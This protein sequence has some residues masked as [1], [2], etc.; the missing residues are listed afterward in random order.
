MNLRLTFNRGDD[1]FV[2]VRCR[3]LAGSQIT[4]SPEYNIKINT[5]PFIDIT[6]P[7]G[8]EI[9]YEYIPIT[10]D[11][12]DSFDYDGDS[13]SFKWYRSGPTG[14]EQFGITALMSASFA[15]GEH[16][17][18][19]VVTDSVEN[20]ASFT[21]VILVEGEDD[22]PEKYTRDTDGDTIP[23][24]WE[25]QYH[26]DYL[27][28]DSDKDPD[29]DGFTNL[30]EYENSTSPIHQDSSPNYDFDQDGINDIW[31]R[32]NGLNHQDPSD[33]EEDPDHDG[34]TN[35]E[36]YKGDTD[37]NDFLSAPGSV[38]PLRTIWYGSGAYEHGLFLLSLIFFI[39]AIFIMGYVYWMI[40]DMKRRG[41]DGVRSY[42]LSLIFFGIIV[43]IMYRFKRRKGN[44][45]NCV[46]CGN[47]R[48]EE[49]KTCPH[50]NCLV[51]IKKVKKPMLRLKV[52]KRK[53][54]IIYI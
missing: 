18:K 46:V 51:K 27:K 34:Y 29:D 3:N 11:A 54:K 32:V 45:I 43:L 41:M 5:F 14:M 38:N 16:T 22:D 21:F 23:D 36:E 53:K 52:L 37:P 8:G 26:L 25:Q 15:P 7:T 12:T 35:L 10:F 49:L 31:E 50:C 44:M 24:Y 40:R 9:L 48:L 47:E 13:I 28:Y 4:E 2:Q 20:S 33:A 30:Q 42:L 6:S 1:N 39:R 19:L 17:I